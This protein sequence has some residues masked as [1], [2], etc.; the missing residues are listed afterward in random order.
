[1]PRPAKPVIEP[2]EPNDQP[3]PPLSSPSPRLMAQ[4][5]VNR[6]RLTDLAARF[7]EVKSRSQGGKTLT[8]VD[9]ASTINRLN[10]VLGM[11]WSFAEASAPVIL[12]AKIERM[13]WNPQTK[14]KDRP[15]VLDGYT[16][17]ISGHLRVDDPFGGKCAYGV[18]ADTDTDIDKVVKTALAEALKKAAHQLGVALYL[19]DEDERDAAQA[20]LTG[21]NQQMRNILGM[22]AVQAGFEAGDEDT[23][24]TRLAAWYQVEEAEL[25]NTETLRRLING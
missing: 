20:Q 5:E 14:R 21:D 25:D 3:A 7:P 24:R 2:A 13:L 1:M 12:P 17:V 4:A 18:G 23:R 22:R 9:I 10:A 15:V 16:C 8:Y 19:W 6:Q 11:D